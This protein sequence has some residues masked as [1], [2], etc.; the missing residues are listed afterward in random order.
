MRKKLSLEVLACECMFIVSNKKIKIYFKQQ[1]IEHLLKSQ[2]MEIGLV[3]NFK[4]QQYTVYRIG[5]P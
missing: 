4:I 5:V 3:F 1:L 2:V